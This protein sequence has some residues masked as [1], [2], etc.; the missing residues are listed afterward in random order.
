M[1]ET[2]VME[3]EHG[4]AEILCDPDQVTRQTFFNGKWF[5]FAVWTE[6]FEKEQQ[7]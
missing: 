1:I 6:N 5:F 4:D 7:F 2:V 3:F